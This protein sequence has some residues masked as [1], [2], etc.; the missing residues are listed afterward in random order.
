MSDTSAVKGDHVKTDREPVVLPVP[1]QIRRRAVADPLLFTKIDP[2]FRPAVPA[3]L[4]RFDFRKD[5]CLIFYGDDVDLAETVPVIARGDGVAVFLKIPDRPV[6]PDVADRPGRNRPSG[7][8]LSGIY[9]K[10]LMN[11]LRCMGDGPTF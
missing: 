8:F 6:F 11:D 9:V 4:T 1:G 5:Q 2:L 3:A 7:R 10:F